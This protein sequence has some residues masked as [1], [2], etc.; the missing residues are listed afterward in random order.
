MKKILSIILT[1]TMVFS[2][3]AAFRAPTASAVL[4]Y[5][6][7]NPATLV[8]PTSAT[9]NGIVGEADAD[10]TS[11]WWGTTDPDYDYIKAGANPTIE[12]GWAYYDISG[13]QSVGTSFS[14]NLTGLTSGTQYYFVAWA[15][16]G[17]VWHPDSVLSFTTVYVT[18]DLATSITPTS[19]TLNGTNGGN[20]ADNTSFWWGTS[21]AGPFTAAVDPSG[22][23][24]SGWSYSST[25]TGARLA[26]NPFNDALTGLT[27]ST[28]YYFVAWSLV[29][30]TWYPGAILNFTTQA[31]ANVITNPATVVTSNDATLNGVNGPAGATGHSFWVSLATFSTAS[32]I[33]PADVYST[34]D[35]GAITANTAF[36]A[37]LSSITTTG[38]PTN[39]PAVTPGTTYY[40]AAWSFVGGTWYPGAILNFTTQAAAN[41]IT[42]PATGVTSTD[43]TLNGTNGGNDADNTSFWWGTSSAGPFTAAVDP[44]GQLP[45]GWSYSS[46][47]T[48]A[49]LA[50]NPFNDALTGLTSGTQYY[51]VAWAQVDGIWYPGDVL[52]FTT[53]ATYTPLEVVGPFAPLMKNGIGI[54]QFKAGSTIPVKFQLTDGTSL[55]TTATGTVTI[56]SA[57][58]SFR[59][60]ATAQQYIANVKTDKAVIGTSVSV[61]LAVDQAGNQTIATIDLR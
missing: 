61:V 44:S 46:T 5:V 2:L 35:F 7:T 13:A 51:F 60:D 49:R 16:V 30:D 50:G 38:V 56:G 17:G 41:V 40:F 9:L 45:S 28:Q 18:T 21:S 25:G 22:Q 10:Y 54:G 31:A 55:I 34:P 39:L 53:S 6:T 8:A 26:G 4:S 24:P 15:R 19:A 1:A 27:P 3:V 20:D 52:S 23:L 59:W 42:N 12:S 58:A 57:S 47:G 43:A 14:H 33:I 37:S 11:F 36:S 48:G 29:G 32:P